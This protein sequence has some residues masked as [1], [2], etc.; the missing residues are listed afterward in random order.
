MERLKKVLEILINND[1]TGFISNRFIGE[2]TRLLFYII[3][4]AEVE[5]IPGL[6][7]IVDYAKPFD[8]IEWNFITGCLKLFNFGPEIIKWIS[9]LCEKSF[10][11]VEQNGNFSD[12]IQLSR[13]YRQGYPISPYLFVLCAE[14]LSHVICENPMI[15][16]ITTYGVENKLTQYSDD[17]TVFIRVEIESLRSV[18]HVLDW[19]KKISGLE[20]NR[21]K[22][23]VIKIGAVRD[24]SIPFEGKF[25][26]EWTENF[27]VL[28][29]KYHIKHMDSINDDNISSKLTE[30]IQLI[31]IWNTRNLKPYGRFCYYKIADL[32]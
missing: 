1:Q 2:N 28:G 29:I 23:K 16:G 21:D 6:L 8:T 22:T 32:F 31:S 19:F 7:I 26:L 4:L 27:E 14:I 20:V 25:G 30:M 5:Q 12:I 24:R 15:K 11:R 17:T 9:L 18:M 10:S 3:N 13:G